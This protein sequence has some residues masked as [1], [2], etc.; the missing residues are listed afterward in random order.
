M[1][2]SRSTSLRIDPRCM[3]GLS[4]SA[5]SRA[6][7]ERLRDLGAEAPATFSFGDGLTPAEGEVLALFYNAELRQARLEA[8]VALANFENAGLW[9]DPE[10]GFDG[11]EILSPSGSPF[12]FGSP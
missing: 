2:D 9:D 4:R 7:L 8:G 3:S 11:A 6:S 12:E 10:F 5:G 1:N